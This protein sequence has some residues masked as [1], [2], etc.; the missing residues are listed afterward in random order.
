V[1]RV[2]IMNEIGHLPIDRAGANF[3]FQ[4]IRRD[5]PGPMIL[6]SNQ[7]CGAW[8]EVFRGS[9]YRLKEKLKPG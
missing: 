8:G 2:L 3:F 1:P 6:T 7:S 4:K 9:S 5:E